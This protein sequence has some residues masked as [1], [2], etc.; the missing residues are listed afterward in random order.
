M[1]NRGGAT[2]HPST[3]GIAIITSAQTKSQLKTNSWRDNISGN[4]PYTA[5]KPQLRRSLNPYLLRQNQTQA[6]RPGIGRRPK[7]GEMSWDDLIDQSPSY[8]AVEGGIS[9]LAEK[10]AHAVTRMPHPLDPG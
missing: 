9:S 6:M 4:Q 1:S 5:R 3:P 7:E 10:A 8:R 2:D